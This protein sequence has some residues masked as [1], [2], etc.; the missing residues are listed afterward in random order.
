MQAEATLSKIPGDGIA[1]TLHQHAQY[2]TAQ[3][4]REDNTATVGKYL[5]Y[6]D[7]R[8][9]YPDFEPIT[10]SAFL[11]ELLSG[12]IKRPYEETWFSSLKEHKAQ[13]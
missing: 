4:I 8:E 2:N 6:L 11:D 5:G 10:I 9:L 1:D 13:N 12:R 7:A 3:F